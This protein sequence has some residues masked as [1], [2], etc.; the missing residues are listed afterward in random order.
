MSDKGKPWIPTPKQAAVM[1]AALKVGVRRTIVD[2][3][4]DADVSRQSF[5]EWLREDDDFRDAWANLWKRAIER[6]LS[7]VIVAMA[8]KAANG[9]VAAARLI[10]DIAG[11]V[12]RK[13]SIEIKDWRDKA[14]Q[15][16]LTDD[17]IAAIEF[18]AEQAAGAIDSGGDG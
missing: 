6:S 4:K 8:H 3:C 18:A 16:G 14:K 5:Y 15:D 2:I 9:D 13:S 1:E 12:S 17:D 10:V 7:P 11:I